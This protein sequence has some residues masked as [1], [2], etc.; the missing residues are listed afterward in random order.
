MSKEDWEEDQLKFPLWWCACLV[1]MTQALS[2][3]WTFENGCI[4]STM[5]TESWCH[6]CRV[7]KSLDRMKW[8]FQSFLYPFSKGPTRKRQNKSVSLVHQKNADFVGFSWKCA[9]QQKFSY[10]FCTGMHSKRPNFTVWEGCQDRYV[11]IS[12]MAILG[13]HYGIYAVNLTG[14]QPQMY[15]CLPVCCTG[16]QNTTQKSIS[17][18]FS[19]SAICHDSS[20]SKYRKQKQSPPGNTKNGERPGGWLLLFTVLAEWRIMTNNAYAKNNG[21]G[22]LCSILWLEWENYTKFHIFATKHKAN[23]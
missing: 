4:T 18:V 19:V 12:V 6:P 16:A 13:F 14:G 2:P 9:N 11:P 3:W 10:N 17:I 23:T 1:G 20:L 7:E 15:W 22:L 5:T 8:H 21:D